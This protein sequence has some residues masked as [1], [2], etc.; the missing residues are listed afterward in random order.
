MSVEFRALVVGPLETNCYIIA[1]SATREGAI[2]DP[3]GDKDRIEKVVSYERI[4]VGRILLTHS[5][6]DHCFYA[7]HLARAYGARIGMHEQDIALLE[8]NLEIAAMFYDMAE[9]L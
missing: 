7:P 1:D 6:F 2:I 9:Y 5:H 8:G 4:H 3:G